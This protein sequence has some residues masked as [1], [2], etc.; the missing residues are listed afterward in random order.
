V[1]VGALPSRDAAGRYSSNCGGPVD[2]FGNCGS[3]YH[4]NPR[5]QAIARQQDK[6]EADYR[7][8]GPGLAL[9]DSLERSSGERLHARQSQFGMSPSPED[10]PAGPGPGQW[11]PSRTTSVVHRLRQQNPELGSSP[12]GSHARRLEQGHNALA[13][14]A[15]DSERRGSPKSGLGAGPRPVDRRQAQAGR[16]AAN[17]VLT[18][19]GILGSQVGLTVAR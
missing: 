9:R 13:A 18:G 7:L 2:D 11:F 1:E 17:T 10:E 8:T 12:G 14:S 6:A 19:D 15:A 16:V 5:C 4:A 3:R